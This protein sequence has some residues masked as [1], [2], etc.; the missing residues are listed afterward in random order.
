MKQYGSH[1]SVWRSVFS[2]RGGFHANSRGASG[3]WEVAVVLGAI[4]ATLLTVLAVGVN[5]GWIPVGWV[6]NLTATQL[7]VLAALAAVVALIGYAGDRMD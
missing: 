7:G 1:G 2:L 5:Q 6:N 4:A 3:I